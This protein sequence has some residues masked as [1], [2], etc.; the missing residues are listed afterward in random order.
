MKGKL[1]QKETE[2]SVQQ[3]EN[4]PITEEEYKEFVEFVDDYNRKLQQ[5]I[6][7]WHSSFI[8]KLYSML[9]K[10]LKK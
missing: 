2:D 1:Q 6:D 3:M 10:I 4:K 7:K 8:Y 5:K 9:L